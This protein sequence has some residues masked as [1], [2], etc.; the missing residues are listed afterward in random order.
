M[1]RPFSLHILTGALAAA[2]FTTTAIAPPLA[3]AQGLTDLGNS[4]AAKEI[5]A[6]VDAGIIAGYGDHTF[7]PAATMTR[8]EFATMLAKTLKLPDDPTASAK[9]TDVEEWAKPYVGALVTASLTSGAS[10]TTFGANDPITR[11]QLAAFFIRALGRSE[12]AKN[13][14]LIS[15]FQDENKTSDYAK[16][17]IALSQHIGFI[18]GSQDKA[19]NWLFDPQGKAERQAVA[20]LSYEFYTK[21]DALRTKSDGIGRVIDVLKRSNEAMNQVTSLHAMEHMMS[22]PNTVLDAELD[23]IAKPFMVHEKGTVSGQNASGQIVNQPVEAYVDDS[24]YYTLLPDSSWAKTQ[25]DLTPADFLPSQQNTPMAIAGFAPY[26]TL[27]ED[28]TS[29]TLKGTVPK[30]MLQ[31]VSPTV[32]VPPGSGNKVTAVSLQQTLVIEKSTYRQT[33][34]HTDTTLSNG[35]I[36]SFDLKL[37]NFNTVSPITLPDAVKNAR[38]AQ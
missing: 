1:K 20:R 8:Q 30:E 38:L 24:F 23:M 34:D 18:L 29:Y 22:P 4:Y 27:T 11:E 37:S 2:L 36:S 14:S 12:Q 17:L 3:Q 19:G 9:F 15:T 5:Q 35:M 33:S 7:H 21:A 25:I 10:P 28:A 6:L 32:E 16:P 13:Y 26:M 31:K